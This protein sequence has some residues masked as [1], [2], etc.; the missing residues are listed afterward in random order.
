MANFDHM[1][2][3]HHGVLREAGNTEE[4]VEDLSLHVPEPA[5]SISGHAEQL[6]RELG[7]W[8]AL[9]AIAVYAFPTVPE[10]HWHHYVP[11]FNFF[12]MLPHALHN[13]APIINMRFDETKEE[14]YICK[15][16]LDKVAH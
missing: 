1:D 7:A 12:H 10:E 6:S 16:E 2:H 4:V 3:I 9:W 5:G 11:L 8:V 15:L 14:N 13:S